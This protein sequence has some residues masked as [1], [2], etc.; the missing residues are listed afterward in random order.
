MIL[1]LVVWMI[2]IPIFTPVLTS[3]GH[4]L[5][6]PLVVMALGMGCVVLGNAFASHNLVGIIVM[7]HCAVTATA[8]HPLVHVIPPRGLENPLVQK[9]LV[10]L[11]APRRVVLLS[12]QRTTPQWQSVQMVVG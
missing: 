7:T 9:S 4:V 3:Y 8:P 10:H 1:F 5:C 6:P 11:V 12:K 2:V